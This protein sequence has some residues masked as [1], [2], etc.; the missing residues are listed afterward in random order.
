MSRPIQVLPSQLINQIAAGEVVERPASVV[1]E[2]VENS[3]D[4]GATQVEVDIQ[5]GGVKLIRIRDNGHGIARQ[6]LPLALSRHATSK[7]ASLDELESIASMGFR[8]EALPSIASVSRLTLV[9]RAQD[10]DLAWQLGGNEQ[11]EQPAA[12]PTGTSVEVADLF[13]NT[14][15]RRKFLKTEQTEFQHIEMV[16][17]R[18]ALGHFETG[19][20]LRHNGRVQFQVRPVQTQHERL[21]RLQE[22]LG[23]PF[24]DST[25]EFAHEAA[26]LRLSGWLARPTFSRSQA[27]M[28]Y[29]YVNGRMVRDKLVTHAVRQAYEDVLY[30]GR[31]PAYLLYLELDPR[32]VDVNVHPAKH[33]VR[34]RDSRLVHDFLFRT[35]HRVIAEDQP[36]PPA[37]VSGV[38]SSFTTAPS[39]IQQGR[40]ALAVRDPA[41]NYRASLDFQQLQPGAYHQQPEADANP[42][43]VTAPPL[44][45]ALAQLHGVFILAQN[46]QGLVLVDMHAAHERITYE[47][48]KF[49]YASQQLRSQ[50]LL[51]PLSVHL[52]MQETE[53]GMQHQSELASFGLEVSRLDKE[54]LVVR[55]IPA[56]LQGA[57]AETLLRDLIADFAQHGSSSRIEEHLNRRLATMACHG[58]VRANKALSVEEMNALLRD[59]ES[60]ERSG[61]CNHGRPTWVALP[62][63]ELDRLFLRGR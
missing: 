28:Q 49:A 51:L 23:K 39:Q 5:Q 2:L 20:T 4:A 41:P 35:L 8:G 42:T 27:D 56:M 63:A 31:H 18:L 45:F 55:S 53:L 15:A 6:Q 43:E 21:A 3:L 62:M 30:H 36:Q 32:A 9:S 16:V 19:F 58:S 22:L 44:G 13:F 17:R 60:T 52:S 61:Q 11:S 29:F 26:G 50:P 57:N 10:Q 34:F 38:T 33:E 46:E 47:R 7:V 59:I 54:T 14:P 25:I 1:K 40:L 37:Q 48:L 24:V 12:H